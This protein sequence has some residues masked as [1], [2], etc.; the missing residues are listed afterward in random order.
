MHAAEALTLAGR[1]SEVRELLEPKLQTEQDDQKRCGLARELVRAGDRRKAAIMHDI[2]TGEDTHGHVHAAESLYKVAEIDDGKSLRDAFAQPS[3]PSQQLMAAAALARHGN[4]DAMKF[5]RQKLAD[6]DPE[7]SRIAAWVLGRIGDHTDIAQLRKNVTAAKD[8]LVRCYSQHA[9]AALGDEDGLKALQENLVST[10]PAIRTYAATF[11]GD[12]RAVS[13]ID[14]LIEL[15]DDT[16]IDVRVRAAQSLLVLSQPGTLDHQQDVSRLV[17]PA[18]DQNPRWT[19]GSIVHLND[20]SLLYAVTQFLDGGS[21]FSQAQIVA[22]RSSDGGRNWEPQRVL[23]KS[24]GKMN[25]MSATLR[26]L[27]PPNN[28]TIAIVLPREKWLRQLTRLCKVLDR[29]NDNVWLASPNH[30]RTGLPCDEQRS[31]H[32]AF[33]RP[34]AGSR[35]IN[36]GR[37]QSQ[38]LCRLLLAV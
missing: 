11:A 4:P 20:G 29:R 15:L 23:Q 13:A 7:V 14:P 16:N 17:Y 37:S 5:L 8:D 27:R 28:D 10:D 35:C 33:Q 1:G 3:S 9:L 34:V 36:S 12:A 21:D 6:S 2:L 26:R 18:T 31:H 25:V 24:S 38:S 32:P 22:R 19:E 30:H